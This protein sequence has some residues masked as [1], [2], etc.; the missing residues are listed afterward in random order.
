MGSMRMRDGINGGQVSIDD[1]C[2]SVLRMIANH[3]PEEREAF[4]KGMWESAKVESA[5]NMVTGGSKDA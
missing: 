2:K 1:W 4:A 5:I 3:N